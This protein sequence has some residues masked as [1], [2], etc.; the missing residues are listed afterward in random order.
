MADVYLPQLPASARSLTWF[1]VAWESRSVEVVA[2]RAPGYESFAVAVDSCLRMQWTRTWFSLRRN[3]CR[4]VWLQR[5]LHFRDV[6]MHR[7]LRFSRR[8]LWDLWR[9][10]SRLLWIA[11]R[12][13][14]GRRYFFGSVF[15]GRRRDDVEH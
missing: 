8:F 6:A 7:R 3:I 15:R 10:C 12:L 1:P 4:I 14:R 2:V 9:R 5:G 11:R 13:W